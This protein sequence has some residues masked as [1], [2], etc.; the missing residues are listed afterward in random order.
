MS[1]C[2]VCCCSFNLAYTANNGSQIII[3]IIN[4]KHVRSYIYMRSRYII[5]HTNYTSSRDALL[6]VQLRSDSGKCIKSERERER[7]TIY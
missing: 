4:N 6:M 7:E 5:Q 1:V 2:C 3:I